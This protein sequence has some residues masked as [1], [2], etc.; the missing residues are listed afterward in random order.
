MDIKTTATIE[1]IKK[2]IANEEYYKNIKE[3]LIL[4][5]NTEL[6]I[7]DVYMFRINSDLSIS[8]V[9]EDFE[10]YRM[11]RFIVSGEAYGILRKPFG[12]DE[13]QREKFIELLKSSN[14]AF[15]VA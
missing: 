1:E 9:L 14:L 7:V 8:F 4:K 11:I 6:I 15:E 10:D 5:G 12:S 2:F 13:Y 3:H